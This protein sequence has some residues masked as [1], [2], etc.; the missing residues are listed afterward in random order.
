MLFESMIEST[1]QR[2]DLDSLCNITFHC[3]LWY[4]ATKNT[5]Y[6][7][8]GK[9]NGSSWLAMMWESLQAKI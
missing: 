7:W 3:G 1:A 5:C 4:L 2:V 8:D 9:M 6:A